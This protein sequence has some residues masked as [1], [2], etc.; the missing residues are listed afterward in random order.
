MTLTELRYLV[1]LAETGHF[2]KAAAACHVSQP[3]LSIALKKLEESLGTVLIERSK[4]QIIPT[5]V[6]EK[7]IAQAKIVLGQAAMI[8]DIAKAGKNALTSPLKIGAI[9]T[10]GP[11]LLPH[12]LPEL[13]QLAPDM[14][15]ILE[16]SYTATLRQRLVNNDL[17]AIL[18][19]LPF[20]EP[21]VVCKPLYEEPFVVLMPDDHSLANKKAIDAKDL[22]TETVLMLGE[23]HCFRDQILAAFPKLKD[24]FL[25]NEYAMAASNNTSLE[26]LKH[27]V[28]GGLGI[29]ILPLSATTQLNHIYGNLITK[30]FSKNAPTRTV[31]LAWRASFPRFEAID[32]ICQA[33]NQCRVL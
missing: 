6:G 26:T 12:L 8:E 3:T 11:Y 32:I 2:G 19:A 16:E 17:D 28:A 33:V 18:I 13:K 29:S 9:Y 21:D 31:A 23:G 20:N 7:V 30:P 22:L 5:A 10:V 14:P 1:T 27:M 25:N 24:S 4:N 15:L